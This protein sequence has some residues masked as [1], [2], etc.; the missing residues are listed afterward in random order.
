MGAADGTGGGQPEPPSQPR[1]FAL[2]TALR[3]AC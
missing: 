1:Q 2:T 3:V